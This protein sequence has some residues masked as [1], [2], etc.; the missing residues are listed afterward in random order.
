MNESPAGGLAGREAAATSLDW[1]SL[2]RSL[3]GAM[4]VTYAV[5]G[6]LLAARQVEDRDGAALELD[7]LVELKAD[8]HCFGLTAGARDQ[9]QPVVGGV[10]G[11]GQGA[12]AGGDGPAVVAVHERELEVTL[13]VGGEGQVGGA[14]G[15][16]Q[17]VHDNNVGAGQETGDFLQQLRRVETSPAGDVAQA[18]QVLLLFQAGFHQLWPHR[19][20]DG[21]GG[22]DS[23]IQCDPRL[24]RISQGG[25]RSGLRDHRPDE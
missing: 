19:W 20:H 23:R 21:Q 15:F 24:R 12:G 4:I 16:G 9:R 11:H 14:E 8:Y 22:V 18:G 6:L 10:G 7:R 5:V 17:A 1:R 3:L 2:T 25:S 13:D